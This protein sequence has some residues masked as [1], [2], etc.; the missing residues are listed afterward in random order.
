MTVGPGLAIVYERVYVA[1]VKLLEMETVVPDI[2]CA[3]G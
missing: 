3:K 1:Q 2:R